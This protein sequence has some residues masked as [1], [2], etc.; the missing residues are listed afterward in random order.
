M[1]PD[2][3]DPTP[4]VREEISQHRTTDEMSPNT[5]LYIFTCVYI[6]HV[7]P[8]LTYQNNNLNNLLIYLHL[9]KDLRKT[10]NLHF[11]VD[12]E[13][14]IKMTLKNQG[15]FW[16]TWSNTK[17]WIV[18]HIETHGCR[19][20]VSPTDVSPT[21]SSWMLRPLN[22]LSLGYYVPDRSVPTL[23]HVTH[24]SHKAGSTAAIRLPIGHWWNWPN[25]T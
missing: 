15:T 9:N 18:Q 11:N 25:L 14:M 13:N 3:C 16:L 20:D 2:Q 6:H 22:K 5:T 10:K 7:W 21:E 8:D 17:R 1:I 23:D 24:G 19:V 12:L 4:S